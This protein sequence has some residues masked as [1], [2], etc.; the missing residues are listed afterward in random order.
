MKKLQQFFLVLLLAG[1]AWSAIQ[2][3]RLAKT[4]RDAVNRMA[5]AVEGAGAGVRS[6]V[7]G[8]LTGSLAPATRQIAAN[9]SILTTEVPKLRQ[10]VGKTLSATRRAIPQV[11]KN[12]GAIVAAV[13]EVADEAVPVERG[14][15]T[16]IAT[17]NL[18][19]PETISRF[20]ETLRAVQFTSESTAETATDALP[21]TIQAAE[22]LTK[23]AAAIA[24]D[25]HQVSARIARPKSWWRRAGAIA[26]ATFNGVFGR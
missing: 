20:N 5:T 14:T 10:D 8:Y 24:D 6:D 19:L 22:Q 21:A 1:A 12:T 16:A 9:S 18:A 15:A 13:K 26:G 3:G 11:V 4:T 17:A 2:V 23:S 7:G 25:V